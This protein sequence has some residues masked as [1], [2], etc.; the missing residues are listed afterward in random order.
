VP[1]RGRARAR[2]IR[3]RRPTTPARLVPR[4]ARAK[5]AEQAHVADAG[6]E[7][8]ERL[9]QRRARELDAPPQLAERGE[10]RARARREPSVARHY[11]LLRARVGA[12]R[13][14]Q[15]AARERGRELVIRVDARGHL[16]EQAVGREVDE[17]GR[18]RGRARGRA[19]S[20]HHQRLHPATNLL[21]KLIITIIIII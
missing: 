14:A 20:H 17:G 1:A 18:A 6:D 9:A 2:P 11:P 4:G 12:D 5:P 15:L 3:V 19:L 16:V 21:L 8:E 7:Q 13:G 10:Q